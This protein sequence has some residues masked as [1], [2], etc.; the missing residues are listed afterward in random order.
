MKSHPNFKVQLAPHYSLTEIDG[1]LVLFSKNTGDFFGLNE[2]ALILLK[3]VMEGDFEAAVKACLTD[4][5]VEEPELRQDILE[6]VEELESHKILK[7]I[8]L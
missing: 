5:Q 4:F 8:L 3:R 7:R 6:L 1:K 2:S